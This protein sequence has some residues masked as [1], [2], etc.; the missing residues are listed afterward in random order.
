MERY[1]EFDNKNKVLATKVVIVGGIV[2]VLLVLTLATLVLQKQ[3]MIATSAPFF[4]KK[5]TRR[6]VCFW[7]FKSVIQKKAAASLVSQSLFSNL[8]KE[9]YST[10]DINYTD[11]EIFRLV[12]IQKDQKCK[13][14]L[15]S[16]GTGHGL[17]SFIVSLEE[18]DDFVFNYKVSDIGE[19]PLQ[20]VDL[21]L[22]KGVSSI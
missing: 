22:Q 19:I 3:Y 14:V 16:E 21:E 11:D 20:D 2:I 13:V 8:E 15:K 4:D 10:V 18:N 7:G 6:D 9:E 17:R 12:K 1:E 5:L